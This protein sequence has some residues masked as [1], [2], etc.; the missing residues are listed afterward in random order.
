[1]SHAHVFDLSR[2]Y[3]LFLADA[4]E[5]GEAWERPSSATLGTAT[6]YG[7]TVTTTD[8]GRQQA[9]E[10]SNGTVRT[11]LVPWPGESKA[12]FTRRRSLATYINLVCP[13]VDA[14]CDA[15][16]PKVTRSLGVLEPYLA[17][18][19]GDGQTW[20]DLVSDAALAA[21]LDGVA[22][23]VIDTP[24][25]NDATNR[26]EE[27]A[28]GVGLRAAVVPLASWAWLREDDGRVCE[29]AYADQATVDDTAISQ[30]VRV[31]VWRSERDEKTGV[32]T[33][34]WSVYEHTLAVGVE[35]GSARAEIMGREPKRTGPL[36]ASLGG[37]L[38]VVFVYHRRVRRSRVPRGQ[39]LAASPAAIGRQVYQ[40]MS[41]IEDVQ[42]RAPPFLSVPTESKGGLEPETAAKVGPDQ[43][44]PAPASGGVPSWVT[45]PAEPLA[46]IRAHIAFLVALAY[47]VAGLEV[48]A[49]ATAQVQS[50]E[51]LRVRSRDFE[52]RAMKFAQNLQ[53]F[54]KRALSLCATL[55]GLPDEATTTYPQRFVQTD[56]A[57]ALA[58]V[59][60]LF[61][62]GIADKLGAD[63]AIEVVRQ[64]VNAAVTL[65]AAQLNAITEELKARASG[66]PE[67]VE[68]KELFAY[69]YDAGLVS[70][71]EARATKGFGPI[72][73]GEVSVLEWSEAIKA[74]VAAKA[75]PATAGA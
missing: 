57:E 61:Q 7:Y 58:S 71:N 21:A 74:R 26:A 44:L 29:F 54:E 24:E 42:R 59:L 72:E 14:Y 23:V 41:M 66:A 73:G 20:A 11:Y 38:P 2:G 15:I 27:Q 65:D 31:W 18:L 62:S 51:A 4:Y 33:A 39:S 34:T 1:M 49:D 70:V 3:S 50:G 32:L 13:I 12:N 64:G 10:V 28:A 35:V 48:Q 22:A 60:L 17:N 68:T 55:L 56:P 8:D 52:A 43:A 9:V 19:D 53:S 36:P 37:R 6:L 46:D 67:P 30:R 16:V 63:G 69:D 40:L 45:F 5:G 47:R 25:K 75:M